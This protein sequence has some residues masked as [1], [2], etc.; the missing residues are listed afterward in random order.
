MP[1]IPDDELCRRYEDLY[2]GL[3]TDVLDERGYRDQTLDTAIEP[4]RPDMTAAGLAF[5]CVGKANHDID[6]DKQIRTFLEML[7]E[8]PENGMLVIGANSDDAAQIGELTTIALQNQ[9]CRGAVVD[10]GTRDTGFIR[11]QDYPAFTRY[12]T[13]ADAITRWELLDWDTTA[14][15]GGVEISPGDVVIG[16]IDGVAVVPG[17]IAGEVLETAE[18]M[19]DDESRVREAIREGVSPLEAYEQYGTF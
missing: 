11:E 1:D 18:E 7:G 2:T 9:G 10:G 4:V 12:L 13:P 6:P 19:R 15:V 3:V 16:D 8:V 17:D 14:V 5:P